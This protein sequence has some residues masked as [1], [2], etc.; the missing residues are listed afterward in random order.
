VQPEKRLPQ[1]RTAT[2]R[3]GGRTKSGGVRGVPFDDS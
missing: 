1:M 2:A 3:D